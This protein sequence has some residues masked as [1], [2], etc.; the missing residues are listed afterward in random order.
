MNCFARLVRALLGST[1][2]SERKLEH[3]PEL[4][5]LGLDVR[6][7]AEGIAVRPASKKVEKWLGVI[8]HARKNKALHSGSASKLAGALNGAARNTFRKLGRALLRALYKQAKSRH[9]SWS[10]E[11]EMALAWWE[12]VLQLG[13]CQCHSWVQQKRQW[14]H[15]YCDARGH[16]AHIAAVLFIDGQRYFCDMAVPTS[17]LDMFTSRRD[18]QILGLELLSIALGPCS[19]V[20]LLSDRCVIV[21]SANS[22]A[23]AAT[24]KGSAKE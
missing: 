16:P 21:W 7:K 8:R 22:G 12:E 11:L 19:F 23:E 1:A 20:Q 14:A 3:G 2:I 18:N 4:V 13:L 10:K 15:L 5:V 24:N 17:V 6:L 9:R